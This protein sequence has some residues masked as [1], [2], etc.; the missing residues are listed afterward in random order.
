MQ[1]RK[2]SRAPLGAETG[3]GFSELP[4]QRSQGF[5][6][7]NS[8]ETENSS[9]PLFRFNILSFDWTCIFTPCSLMV[10]VYSNFNFFKTLCSSN[11]EDQTLMCITQV[12]G[13]IS[14][15]FMALGLQRTQVS[16]ISVDLASVCNAEAAHKPRCNSQVLSSLVSNKR[17]LDV[18]NLKLHIGLG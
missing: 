13:V 2:W 12:K 1:M 8:C 3:V 9:F 16:H 4:W 17:G 7:T 6:K 15:P 18:F 10:L 11:T 14:L 5:H